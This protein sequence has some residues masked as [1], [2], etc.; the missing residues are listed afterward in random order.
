MLQPLLFKSLHRVEKKNRAHLYFRSA[1]VNV[2]NELALVPFFFSILAFRPHV[3]GDFGNQNTQAFENGPLSG[4]FFK[5]TDCRFRE[6]GQKRRFQ[7][8][9]CH[10]RYCA[11][12]VRDAVG[13]CLRGWA[14]TIWISYVWMPTFLKERTK[15]LSVFK[16]NP[17][18]CGQGPSSTVNMRWYSIQQFWNNSCNICW[19]DQMLW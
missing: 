5:S 15:K 4:D 19:L 2:L 3:N 9:W 8:R 17:D 10:T 1:T 6:D 7:I 18:T 11:I 12:T 16:T 13:L 14:K